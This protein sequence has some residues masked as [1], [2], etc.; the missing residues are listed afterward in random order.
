MN[1]FD[2]VAN[3]FERHRQLPLRVPAAIRQA[4]HEH[5]GLD[6]Q[7]PLLE[8]GCGTG[9]IGAQFC[10][11]GDNYLGVDASIGMLREFQQKQFA[12]TPILLLADGHRLP[13]RDKIFEAVLMTHLQTA[14]NWGGLLA[15][16]RRV[17][18]SRGVL[19]IGK[20]HG[21][22]DG[23]DAV[24]RDQLEKLIGGMGLNGP[25]RDRGAMNEWLRANS[26]RHLEVRP[27]DWIEQRTP[28]EF[29]L[30][31]QSAARFR[32]LPANLREAALRSLADWAER[33]IGS[34][35]IPVCESYHFCLELHW[36][37]GGV[38]NHE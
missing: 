29:L 2:L 35:D 19:A 31:K 1:S 28:R 32:S 21:P 3:R 9:R 11:A 10:A 23:I 33:N 18:Q 13:F 6:P 5:G 8:I 37:Q 20:A 16:A 26:A 34:L 17:L 38:A 12:R 7:T 22:P 15:E 30:R 24:M 14:R 25:S 36:L 4:L 27:I